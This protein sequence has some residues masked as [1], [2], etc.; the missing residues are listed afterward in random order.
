MEVKDI[1]QYEENDSE[2]AKHTIASMYEE[3]ARL[4]EEYMMLQNASDEVEEEKDNEI[5]RL[6]KENSDLQNIT[7]IETSK[8]KYLEKENE[9]LN[10]IIK[11]A[12][13]YISKLSSKGRDCEIYWDIKKEI[14]GILDKEKE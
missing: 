12:R 9:R 1:A 14:L 11:E 4:K 10:N 13:E 3:I 2:L 8:N 7:N 5:E 6:N